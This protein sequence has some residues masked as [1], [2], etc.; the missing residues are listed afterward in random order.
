MSEFQHFVDYLYF[1]H[2]K[3][4]LYEFIENI[5]HI[6]WMLDNSIDN[7]R[8]IEEFRTDILLPDPSFEK[9]SFERWPVVMLMRGENTKHVLFFSTK[10]DNLKSVFEK[11]CRVISDTS[12]KKTIT[13]QFRVSFDVRKNMSVRN[14]AALAEHLFRINEY[15]I[16]TIDEYVRASFSHAVYMDNERIVTQTFNSKRQRS[17]KTAFHLLHGHEDADTNAYIKEFIKNQEAANMAQVHIDPQI[18]EVTKIK[19]EDLAFI[20]P[21][22]VTMHLENSI[23]KCVIPENVQTN[24][25]RL[26]YIYYYAKDFCEKMNSRT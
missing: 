21:T 22:H 14:A 11:T 6:V 18:L 25:Y 10:Q 26:T 8:G 7:A 2:S 19:K 20:I 15:L 23:V 4:S 3:D 13:V 24:V 17:L 12:G 1:F 16:N 9:D 5:D